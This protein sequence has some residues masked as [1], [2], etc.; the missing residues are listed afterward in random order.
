M[1]INIANNSPRINY[2][3]TSG[4]TVFTVPFEFF[5]NTDLKVY[6]EGT[7]KTITTHYTVSG[8]NGSTG[9]VTLVT[10]ATLNDEVTLVR[11]VPMERTTDL[12]ANY[13]AASL[14]GQLDRIVAE[15]ADLDDRVSRTIQ[16]NDYELA[17]GLL[18]PALDS[19][20]GKTIQFNTST[21]AL[22]VG[23]TGAD[24]TA[25]GSVTSEIATL[26]G[27]SGNITTVAGSN[28]Q[29]V[30]VGNAMTSIT[31][32]NSAL[33]NVNTVAGGISNINLVG[34]SIADVN[35]V[36]DS[37]GEISAVQ[38]K[39]TNIDTV[40]VASTNIGTVAGSIA[41][42]NNVASKIADVT[43]VNTNM[44]AIT[45][46]NA[47]SSNINL[48]ANS[49]DDVNDVGAVITKVTTVADNITNVNLVGPVAQYMSDVANN[50]T[51]IS[52]VAPLAGDLSNVT[53][54]L[55]A[56]QG[57]ATNA[58]NAANS[59]TAAANSA[60][61]IGNAETTTTANAV[62]AANSA[63][64]AA[65]AL[66]NFDDKYLGVKSSDPTVDNDGD[67]L[68]QGA[69]YFSSSSS[70][71]QVYDGANWIAASSSGVASLT[72]FEY[73]ATAGQT[74]FSGNDDNGLSMSFIAANL[75]V[76][77]NGVILDPSDYTTTSG[78]T[79]TLD[80]GAAVGDVV[81]IY[82]FKS[83]QVADTVP[84]TTGGTF[85]GPVQFNSN[86]TVSGTVDGVD[87]AAFKTSFDN[88]STDIVSDTTPQLGG[89][90]ASNGNDINF[91]DN[92]KAIFGA[93]SDLKIYHSSST[94]NSVI[95]ETGSGNLLIYASN[96]SMADAGGN[97]FILMTDTGTG[98]TV[99]LKHNT[100]TKLA[101]TSTGIDVTGT[102]VVDGLTSTGLTTV[103]VGAETSPL[104]VAS[105]GNDA[106]VAYSNASTP[107]AY[108]VRAGMSDTDDFSIWTSD[109]KRLTVKDNGNVGIGTTSPTNKLF[110]E[111][112]TVNNNTAFIKNTSGTGVNY[113]LEIAAG[114]N[115]TDHS[116][117]VTSSTGTSL[118]RVNGAGNVGIG[119]SNPLSILHIGTGTNANV[120]ITFA[121]ST[122]GNIEFRNTS[123]TGTFTITNGNGSSEKMRIDSSGNVGIG[124]STALSG[125]SAATALRIGSQIN[126]YEYDDG[127]NPVQMNINQN[128]DAS[129]NYI[130][131]DQA[132]RYQMRDGVHKWFTVGSGTAGTASGIGSSEKMRIDSSGN[133]LV[134]KTSDNNALE[135][136]TLAQTGAI[137][138][139][140]SE[141]LTGIFN[142][143]TTDGDIVQFWKG[144]A[145]IGSIGTAGGQS[146]IQGVNGQTGLYWGTNNI[147]PYRSNGINDNT[148]NLG[149]TNYRFDDI[150][151]TNGTI[152]TSD[153]NEKQDIASLT[154]TEMLVGK[155]IS[156]LFKTFRWKDSVEE[157]GANARTHTGVIA[158]DVQAAF[159]AEGLDAGD[160][161]LFISS[162]WWEHDV[163]VPAVEAVAEVTDEDGNVTTEA[164]E[165]VDAYTRTD[166]YDTEAEAPEGATS[167][168][169]LGIRYPELLSFVAA[170]NEQR[171][172]SI[173][174]RLTAL[175]DV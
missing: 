152:Q 21:G 140:N 104:R 60:T 150:F 103:N 73:T 64:A 13:N 141:D 39:L 57:A 72:L 58:T 126:I 84:A 82:A 12:T 163:D 38:A 136:V 44:S 160:Y 77:M 83:F 94:N 173:E 123:S 43:G 74:A 172:A 93:G 143:L 148:I 18:L 79:V 108:Y 62:A 45:T 87:I 15:I 166:T 88:L 32:I 171:F 117:H 106:A 142:R 101:T 47:N 135:G 164:V 138:A 56:I 165:A 55:S 8:G 90:L 17:S 157:N 134:G 5:D 59:A 114:T 112:S 151:A 28:A 131:T 110:V 36:A 161:A 6:I 41:Q 118:L 146:Y 78:L 147:F 98:G 80:V 11:D 69:L 153:F 23:P 86:V 137:K 30:A 35:D 9:T 169:R 129:E 128:I 113:G 95:Q 96:I 76:T 24:L 34:G 156:A 81:N 149:Q 85:I 48:V 3:A 71:M 174:A 10:G 89:D 99:E 91:A 46:A 7:L 25:I 61:S 22:E 116:L 175:E 42:V 67:A 154:A 50:I 159:T 53:N 92:D 133:V 70:A 2:T 49:I 132:A 31:A 37:L 125:P 155:R 14:D 54:N 1:T 107:T 127:S 20:K 167:K 121:P 122:G 115:A 97:E 100:S 65:T 120:P 75:L 51:A 68:I 168:T 26:A 52:A 63:A 16:I 66:D 33:S 109:T 144:G 29:V 27:I 158:Q 105:T 139:T 170:Y 111:S 119:D 162:T 145:N 19:R 124:T 102:A 130:T 40:A 4:Q